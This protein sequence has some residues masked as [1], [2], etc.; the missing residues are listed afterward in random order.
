MS[1]RFAVL[2]AAITLSI[3]FIIIDIL[4]V[5]HVIDGSAPD[6]I[7]PFW[8]LSF[9]FKCL[10][11]TVILDDFKTALDR[12]KQYKLRRLST[13]GAEMGRPSSSRETRISDPVPVQ[14][15]RA[16]NW[17]RESKS[18]TKDWTE[19]E[20]LGIEDIDVEMQRPKPIRTRS[21]S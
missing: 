12:L 9:V 19:M 20:D 18:K 11:D 8:K 3:A 21:P 13:F 14:M 15:F 7:N 16:P 6:G 10:T 17:G 4:A 1:P 5:T 2:L